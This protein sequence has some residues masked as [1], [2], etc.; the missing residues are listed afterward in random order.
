MTPP[1]RFL[2]VA[3]L[4]VPVALVPPA[5]PV[6]TWVPQDDLDHSRPIKP[7]IPERVGG[8]ADPVA[9][10]VASGRS[11]PMPRGNQPCDRRPAR[12][13]VLLESAA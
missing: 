2:S 11:K 5:I 3:L 1:K 9:G 10:P 13:E 6:E 7:E 4:V 12:R 8:S